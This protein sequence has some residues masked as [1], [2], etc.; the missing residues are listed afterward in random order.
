MSTQITPMVDTI[1]YSRDSL[2]CIALIIVSEH[3]DQIA[4][5]IDEEVGFTGMGVV[6]QRDS[7][8]QRF[9]IFPMEGVLDSW[10]D[11]ESLSKDLQK[12]YT[13]EATIDDT[14]YGANDPRIFESAH[15]FK[16][17]SDGEYYFEYDHG[18]KK[19]FYSNTP[20]YLNRKINYL[21]KD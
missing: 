13:K 21:S 16:K 15:R 20:Q 2:L 4:G 19:D 5:I 7:I 9:R 8:N 6:G 11:Y 17:N 3:Y 18:E 1:F 10:P 12:F 14:K